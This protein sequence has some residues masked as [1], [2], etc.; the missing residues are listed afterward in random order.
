MSEHKS[1]IESEN[2]RFEEAKAHD[3]RKDEK[4]AAYDVGKDENFAVDDVGKDE[5][6]A[7]D[8]VGKEEDLAVDDVRKDE[9]FVVDDVGKDEKFAVDDV[10]KDENIAVDVVGKDEDFAGDDV[11]KDENLA[12][13]DAGKDEN[14]AVDDAR[15][16]ED[17]AVDDV[18]K[19][20]NFVENAVVL[21][22][23]RHEASA[24]HTQPDIP[25][26]TGSALSRTPDISIRSMD[27]RRR[28]HNRTNDDIIS[29]EEGV[30]TSRGGGNEEEDGDFKK[31]RN[32]ERR[33]I[34]NMVKYVI[35]I[36]LIILDLIFDWVQYS[37][38]NNRGNYS[39]VAERR[40]KNVEVT[41]DCEGK[42][43]DIQFIFLIFTVVGTVMTVLQIL[44]IVYQ[45]YYEMK[46][47]YVSKILVHETVE[48]F[49]FLF[50][51]ELSQL[52]LIMG[53]Y[54][55]CTLDCI[56]NKTEIVIALN[57]LLSF[58]KVI[59]RFSTRWEYCT[60]RRL[61]TKTLGR[62]RNCTTPIPPP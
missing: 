47:V 2:E 14:F 5:N 3:V 4:F 46:G 38:M 60:F 9:N 17:L 28:G 15:K 55:A 33:R 21:S 7:V 43:K 48:T 45:I 52:L 25:I 13:D 22:D 41:F 35:A 20:D 44:N 19:D 57:G 49:L 39:I 26:E 29:S 30:G 23:A 50:F 53:F 31:K 40:M 36:V 32:S 58:S 24:E 12:V 37:E 6:L 62:G 61:N 54:D 34:F 8:A 11:R 1:N 59:W 16:D 42:G 51:I 18:G 27:V 10:G 56:I